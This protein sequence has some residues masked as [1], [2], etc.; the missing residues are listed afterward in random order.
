MSRPQLPLNMLAFMLFCTWVLD[1]GHFDWTGDSPT[2]GFILHE[3][4]LDL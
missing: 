4:P 2:S 1:A 3:N